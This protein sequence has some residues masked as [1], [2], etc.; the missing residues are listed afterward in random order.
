MKKKKGGKGGRGGKKIEASP[1]PTPTRRMIRD[2]GA[3]INAA[4]YQRTY[5]KLQ[6]REGGKGKGLRVPAEEGRSYWKEQDVIRQ[7]RGSTAR[8][9]FEK[10]CAFATES[11]LSLLM[12][13]HIFEKKKK[14]LLRLDI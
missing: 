10:V 13:R 2:V 12:H 3:H 11:I 1:K 9:E 6:M 7:Q 5:F 8:G 4:N 14:N